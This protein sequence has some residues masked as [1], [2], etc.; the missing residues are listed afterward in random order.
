[1]SEFLVEESYFKNL[2]TIIFNS[3]DRLLD[4]VN[5]VPRVKYFQEHGILPDKE[6]TDEALTF[7]K[8]YDIR[9]FLHWLYDGKIPVNMWCVNCEFSKYCIFC[10]NCTECIGLSFSMYCRGCMFSVQ[11]CCSNSYVYDYTNMIVSRF[12]TY[13]KNLYDNSS[14]DGNVMIDQWMH[15]FIKTTGFDVVTDDYIMIPFVNKYDDTTCQICC[16]DF[17]DDTNNLVCFPCFH[18]YCKRCVQELVKNNYDKCPICVI[19]L[20]KIKKKVK[21]CYKDKIYSYI[22]EKCSKGSYKPMINRNDEL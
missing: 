1:M 16:T 11:E 9:G 10:V 6:L 21:S 8:E 7:I 15:M 18:A 22:D 17:A 3:F 14:L 13:E 12:K 5:Y 4:G 2:Y 20:E 19:K